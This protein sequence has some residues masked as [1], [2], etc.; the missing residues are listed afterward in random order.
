[1]IHEHRHRVI[2]ILN[3]PLVSAEKYDLLHVYSLPILDP[4]TNLYHTILTTLRYFALSESNRQYVPLR[5]LKDCKEVEANNWICFDKI[6]RIID[7]SSPCEVK[8]PAANSLPKGCQAS[9]FHTEEYNIQKLGHN[10]WLAFVTRP[11]SITKTCP[12]EIPETQL[13]VNN[14][15]IKLQPSCSAFIGSIQIFASDTKT[16]NISTS[17]ELPYLDFDCCS[18]LPEQHKIPKLT[19]ISISN[20]NL[21][22]LYTAEHKLNQQSRKIDELLNE[23]FA[24]RHLGTFTVITIVCIVL[25]VLYLIY[26]RCCRKGRQ[27]RSIEYGPDHD[28]SRGGICLNVYNNCFKKKTQSKQPGYSAEFSSRTESVIKPND[29]GEKSESVKFV[30][31][32]VA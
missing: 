15:I 31:K 13:I 5:D 7:G 32:Q 14:S 9:I 18:H 2:F 3:V 17:L 11:T 10:S 8:L 26:R 6:P 30:R 21:D 25:L 20:I 1:M 4:R 12:S 19:P 29:D 28:S 16:S 23:N 22:E 24:T 27:I